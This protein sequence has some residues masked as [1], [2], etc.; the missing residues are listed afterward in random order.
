MSA[1]DAL[2]AEVDAEAFDDGSL[3]VPLVDAVVHVLPVR[4][5]RSSSVRAMRDG[6][7]DRWAE[8]CLAEG[9]YALWQVIDPDMDEIEAFFTE[10][11]RLSGQ[12]PGKSAASSRSS[13]STARR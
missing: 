10:W 11:T 9:D 4:K 6:D 5:W 12:E 2:E 1:L 8:K 3:A 13:R 7:F